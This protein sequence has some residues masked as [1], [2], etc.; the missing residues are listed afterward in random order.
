MNG[1]PRNFDYAVFVGRSVEL[2]C[3]N[4]TQIYLHFDQDITVTIEGE[5]AIQKRTMPAS[6]IATPA[7]DPQLASLIASRVKTSW[8]EGSGTLVLA[9]E[10][11]LTLRCFDSFPNYES[12]QIK[13]C[14]RVYI[15]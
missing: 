6:I 10:N 13:I 4:E 5:Y 14:D 2:I 9:F 11:E 8:A 1:L 7:L 12:Y 3:F 15:I